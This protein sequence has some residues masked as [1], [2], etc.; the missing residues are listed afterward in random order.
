[1]LQR[2]LTHFLLQGKVVSAFFKW[3]RGSIKWYAVFI[4]IVH[5]AAQPALCVVGQNKFAPY[6]KAISRS[7]HNYVYP[8]I[9][10]AVGVVVAKHQKKI[11]QPGGIGYVKV[12]RWFFSLLPAMCGKQFVFF[13]YINGVARNNE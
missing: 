9:V 7:I 8:Q 2:V 13:V 1:M 3:G 4:Y 5:A 11:V 6:V 12:K 10:V